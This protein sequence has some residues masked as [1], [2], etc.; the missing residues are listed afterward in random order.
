MLGPLYTWSIQLSVING[1]S[2]VLDTGGR[3]SESQL[4]SLAPRHPNNAGEVAR[5]KKTAHLGK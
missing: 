3:D 4:A 2:T 5:L 1:N